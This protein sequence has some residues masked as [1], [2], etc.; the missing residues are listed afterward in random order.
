MTD[1]THMGVPNRAPRRLGSILGSL[2]GRALFGALGL[3]ILGG[4][5]RVVRRSPWLTWL[6]VVLGVGVVTLAAVHAVA[7]Q[8]ASSHL[9]NASRFRRFTF[10]IFC[11]LG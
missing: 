9:P 2:G 8:P 10:N 4:A 7:P 5:L 6:A 3:L 11:S 1:K